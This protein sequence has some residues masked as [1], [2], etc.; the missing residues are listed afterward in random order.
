MR[1]YM[2]DKLFAVLRAFGWNVDEKK[3][4]L[5]KAIDELTVSDQ[6]EGI[7]AQLNALAEQN[8]QLYEALTSEKKAREESQKTILEQMKKDQELKIA[9]TLD[10]AK[11]V[12][13]ITPAQEPSFKKLLEEDF[14]ATVAV[15]AGLPVHPAAHK[16]KPEKQ[17]GSDIPPPHD[18]VT[19]RRQFLA[20][21][22]AEFSTN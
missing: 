20:D 13:K 15:I 14:D 10:E 12:G 16:A 2:K 1:Y 18:Y 17:P 19:N 21:A 22:K 8:K 5:E 4:E 6:G 9:K 7:L 11:A 3:V